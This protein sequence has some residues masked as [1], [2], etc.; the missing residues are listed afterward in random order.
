MVYG[1]IVSNGH[2]FTL[3][4]AKIVQQKK[5]LHK[6]LTWDTPSPATASK[7]KFWDSGLPASVRRP[8]PCESSAVGR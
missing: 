5:R 1:G 3:T 2:I 8:P 4:S 6:T 7:V